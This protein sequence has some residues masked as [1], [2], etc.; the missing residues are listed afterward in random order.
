MWQRSR[1]IGQRRPR[2][3][4]FSALRHSTCSPG[5]LLEIGTAVLVLGSPL[6][7]CDQ[8]H[9]IPVA[10]QAIVASSFGLRFQGEGYF[11]TDA[12]THRGSSGAPVVLRLT[13]PAPALRPLPWMLLGVHS[14]RLDVG[15]REVNED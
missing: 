1:S 6:G 4:S 3:Q 10:R 9:R 7:F 12:R 14:A 11:L 5:R 8:L 2:E 13:D 15:S